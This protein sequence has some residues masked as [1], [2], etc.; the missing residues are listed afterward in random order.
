MIRLR[1]KNSHRRYHLKGYLEV[2]LGADYLNL[3]I[4][5]FIQEAIKCTYECKCAPRGLTSFSLTIYMMADWLHNKW[6]CNVHGFM[7][8]NKWHAEKHT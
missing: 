7:Q 2:C 5:N 8:T 1:A 3:R 4:W 6:I